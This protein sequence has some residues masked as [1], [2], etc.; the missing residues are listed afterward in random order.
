MPEIRMP[1]RR[2]LVEAAHV[3]AFEQQVAAVFQSSGWK[4]AGGGERYGIF[5]CGSKAWDMLLNGYIP[6]RLIP[7]EIQPSI[8]H[9]Y[10]VAET[11]RP[12]PVRDPDSP[13]AWSVTV[14]LSR[15]YESADIFDSVL[16]LL[17]SEESTGYMHIDGRINSAYDLPPA[18]I[19]FPSVFRKRRKQL[20][21]GQ[22]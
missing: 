12:D 8:L 18:S 22:A 1:A 14:S 16:S 17:S 10:A 9:A 13:E 20:L 21:A 5:E 7:K 3:P 15:G 2:F 19:G 6:V 4:Q 11:L